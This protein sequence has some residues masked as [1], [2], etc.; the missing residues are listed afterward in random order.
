MCGTGTRFISELENGK[1]TLHI[2][3]V[4]SILNALGFDLFVKER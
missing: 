2:N 4:F 3:K 1:P